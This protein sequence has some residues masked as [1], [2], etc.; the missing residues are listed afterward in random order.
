MIFRVDTKKIIYFKIVHCEW[1]EWQIGECSQT[2]GGGILTKIRQEKTSAAHG[3]NECKGE[4]SIEESC[5]V[6][7]C[8]GNI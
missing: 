5:N 8:P 3:G 1:D 4:D 7:E 2:C 6:Q